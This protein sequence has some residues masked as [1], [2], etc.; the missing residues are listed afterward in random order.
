MSLKEITDILQTGKMD[1]PNQVRITYIQGKNFRWL[2]KKI[3]E[4]TNNKEEDV[5]NLVENK[6][7][8]SSL[9]NDYWFITNDILDEDI[10]YP[11]E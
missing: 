5:Y 4:V 10:Y 3:A 7:Y 11:L 2:A 6:E 9:I 1:N 8:L